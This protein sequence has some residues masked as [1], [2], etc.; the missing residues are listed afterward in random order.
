MERF[1]YVAQ[2]L[3]KWAPAP[4]WLSKS[5]HIHISEQNFLPN[6]QTHVKIKYTENRNPDEVHSITTKIATIMAICYITF[7]QTSPHL[8]K[9]TISTASIKFSTWLALGLRDSKWEN[10]L[11]FF[12]ISLSRIIF[13]YQIG[14]T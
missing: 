2:D 14:Y 8:T 6:S 5:K 13:S 7:L 4:L 12:R 11:F 3:N 9:L 1:M 10:M